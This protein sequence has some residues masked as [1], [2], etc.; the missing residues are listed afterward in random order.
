[1]IFAY[2]DRDMPYNFPCTGKEVFRTQAATITEAD[3]KFESR[4]AKHPA[5][6]KYI[7]CQ[8]L[9]PKAEYVTALTISHLQLPVRFIDGTANKACQGLL[10]TFQ[11]R[12]PR[13]IITVYIGNRGLLWRLGQPFVD[14]SGQ[15]SVCE[16]GK[17]PKW[18]AVNALPT[19]RLAILSRYANQYTPNDVAANQLY[20]EEFYKSLIPI[21]NADLICQA[22]KFAKELIM[23]MVS[24]IKDSLDFLRKKIAA[25]VSI[26]VVLYRA[27]SLACLM[28][29]YI[30]L[31]NRFSKSKEPESEVVDES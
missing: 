5:S 14:K 30:V 12:G 11:S 20:V 8:I 19:D 10:N 22:D 13:G 16:R 27:R 18:V 7:G 15:V 21:I 2:I 26:Y 9:K 23:E 6:I 29:N 3:A 31:H 17:E 1:M 28:S 24:E 4:F 25:N